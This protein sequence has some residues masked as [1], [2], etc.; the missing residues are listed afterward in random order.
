M[1][2]RS[3]SR[4]D[5]LSP[6]V[7]DAPA[8]PLPNPRMAYEDRDVA[9]DATPLVTDPD[10]VIEGEHGLVRVLIMNDRIHALTVNTVGVVAVWDI[11]RCQCL[12]MFAQEDV[13]NANRTG[14]SSVSSGAGADATGGRISPRQAL[15]IVRDRI[16][17][18]AVV[19]PWS[20]ADTKIGGL[21]VHILDK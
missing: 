4:R 5:T 6:P 11:V 21:A 1:L 17:G 9:P 14:T 18:E 19:N 2:F 3:T 15:E 10:L 8:F 12:G 13:Q 16:E 20:F 7:Q